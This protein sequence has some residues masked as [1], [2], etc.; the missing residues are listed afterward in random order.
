MKENNIFSVK[1]GNQMTFGVTVVQDGVQ[2]AIYMPE[3]DEGSCSLNLYRKGA[4]KPEIVIDLTD[5]YKWGSMYFVTLSKKAGVQDTRSTAQILSEDYEYTYTTDKGEI[6]DSYAS[7][8]RGREEWGKIPAGRNGHI[9]GGISLKEFDWENDKSPRRDFSDVIMYQL[10]VRG[11]T[12]SSSSG[13]KHKGTFAGVMEKIPYLK[14][15][16]INAIM[17]LPC[18]EFNE[19]LFTHSFGEPSDFFKYKNKGIPSSDNGMSP[20]AEKMM[21]ENET[22]GIKL[23]YWGYGAKDTC[24]FAPKTSFAADKTDASGEM[25]EMVKAL[26]KN[27]IEVLMDIYFSP[28]TNINMMTECLRHWVL[29]YHIDGFRVNDDVMPS[30]VLASD[31]LLS[32]VKLLTTHWDGEALHKAGAVKKCNALAEYNEGFMND[33]RRF[34]KSDEGMVGKY[35]GRATRNPDEYSVINFMTHVNGFTLMDLVS[36]DVKHNESN[37]E[38]NTDGTDFNYSWNCGVEGPSRKK[39]VVTRRM[40]QIRN[41]VMMMMT[42]QGTPM[43]L[44]GDEL[45]N[46]QKGNNNPYCHD[47]DITW[48]NWRKTRTSEQIFDFFRKAIAFRKKYKALHQKK[49][50]LFMDTL[51]IG[52]PD[53]SVHGTGAWRPDYSNYNRMLGLLYFGGA[54]HE[55]TSK[56]NKDKVKEIRKT[57]PGEES[58]F[59]I[60]NMYWEAKS[61]D[62]PRLPKDKEWYLAVDTFSSQFNSVPEKPEKKAPL[63]KTSSLAEN[64]KT[65]V[66]ARSIEVFIGK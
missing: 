45:G 57:A 47:D 59:V 7:V 49:R 22:P 4:E 2:F 33:A 5:E 39:A 35:V 17:L 8:I 50:L 51:G 11:F 10:H 60:F 19:I 41:A 15:L 43:I 29:E 65:I 54:C 32:G 13:V 37:G 12:K 23:N 18:Y 21:R 24:Y 64:K 56:D 53:V 61:F 55:F 30:V 62:L 6:T 25:K 27:G 66:P 38:N 34:L 26:H 58:V 3:D 1:Q 36:Y 9:R 42:S 48:I 16:G 40:R 14:D 52:I 63:K 46:T 20:G 31:P 28:G 44:A